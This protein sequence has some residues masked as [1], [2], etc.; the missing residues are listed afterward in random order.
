MPEFALLSNQYAFVTDASRF[1]AYIGG[2]GSGKTYGGAV[3]VLPRLAERGYGMIAAPT[4]PMLRDSTRRTFLTVLDQAGIPFELHKSENAITI[5]STGH[6]V[7]C[8]SLD[9]P[10]TLRGPNLAYAW[11]DEAALVSDMAWRIVKG[12]VRDGDH[13]QAWITTTP[14]GR[15]WI[16]QE[17]VAEPDRHHTIYRTRTQ[18]NR[19]L[20]EDFAESLGYSGRFAEQELGGEFVAFE[21]LVYPMFDRSQHVAVRDCE[22]WETVLGVDIGT[23]NPTAIVTLRRSGDRRHVEREFYR[24]GMSSEEIIEAISSEVERARPEAVYIDPSANDYIL[25]L[26]RQGIPAIKANNDVTYGIGIVTTALADGLTVDPSCVNLIAEFETYHYPENRQ[27]SDKPVKEAD[28]ALDSLRYC[29]A[30]DGP[31]MTG[32]LMY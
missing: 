7:I 30:S 17:W 14:K 9:N 29:L 22:D 27:E 19:H 3:K 26:T 18:E 21:G 24:R 1:A 4:Y 25:T 32:E 23:R 2:I 28:H 15:N 10:E 16:W 13:P 6:E 8:R 31:M 20:P 12:R 5:P 11:V